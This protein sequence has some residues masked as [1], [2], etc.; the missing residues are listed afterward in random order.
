M[1]ARALAQEAPLLLLDEPTTA[2]DVGRQQEALELIDELRLRGRADGVATMHDLTLAGQY[3]PRLL[4]LYG[5]RIVAQGTPRE[6]L[7]EAMVAEHYG[8]RVRVVEDAVILVVR[9]GESRRSAGRRAEREVGAGG[10]ARRRAGVRSSRP[11]RPATR[12]WRRGS[13]GIAPSGRP[14]GRRSRSRSSCAGAGGRGADEAVVVDCLSLWVANL[15]EAGWSDDA[16]EEEAAV[17]ASWRPP[18]GAD[19]RG[20]ERGRAWDRARYPARP[21]LPGPARPRQRALGGRGRPRR[22]RCRREIEA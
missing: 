14:G 11:G 22:A 10:D 4:L 3:A 7:T 5:G 16:I 2:L 15:I 19:D 9:P 21:A 6:V 8:A 17:A 1:L 20:V 12:R 18:A 13:S